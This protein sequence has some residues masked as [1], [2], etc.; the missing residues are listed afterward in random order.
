MAMQS[1]LGMAHK[2]LVTAIPLGK[3]RRWWWEN[4]YHIPFCAQ[5]SFFNCM[6]YSTNLKS[7]E[8]IGVKL[9]NELRFVG[10]TLW[11]LKIQMYPRGSIFAQMRRRGW[12]A[13]RTLGS[14][15]AHVN[16]ISR[17]N[18][19]GLVASCWMHT[20]IHREPIFPRENTFCFKW[21]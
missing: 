9:A 17:K 8:I 16:A 6:V 21:Q 2:K 14:G 1:I 19:L 4:F 5:F 3:N 10:K 7:W 18:I 11:L 12:T 13:V 20:H 15:T